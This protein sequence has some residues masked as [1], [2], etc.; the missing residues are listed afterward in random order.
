MS[1]RYRI[2]IIAITVFGVSALLAV[3]VGI[4]LY[5]GFS[6][7]AQTTR[8]LWADQAETLIDTI[9]SN[10]EERLYPV[11]DQ[12]LWVADDVTDLSDLAALDDYF[13]GVLAATPQVAGIAVI[14][15]DGHSR[16]WHR[17]SRSAIDEDWSTRAWIHEYIEQV[18]MDN[19]ASWREP[20]FTDTLNSSTLLAASPTCSKRAI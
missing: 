20:I 13:F 10:L 12:A 17:D 4:V 1:S 6:Q 19:S 9:E 7:A 11:R 5:L 3:S 16:R 2:P 18:K 8:Q 15:A 14:S